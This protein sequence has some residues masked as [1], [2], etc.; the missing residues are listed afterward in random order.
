MLV[1]DG[2][3][4]AYTY[5]Y[6]VCVCVV[7]RRQGTPLRA[8]P[9][10]A[11][12]R[13]R[14]LHTHDTTPAIYYVHLFVIMYRA[15]TP[16]GKRS[17]CWVTRAVRAIMNTASRTWERL[18]WMC[19]TI[20]VIF[21]FLW[22]FSWITT[23]LRSML[24]CVYLFLCS[25]GMTSWNHSVNRARWPFAAD[26]RKDCHYLYFAK[27]LICMSCAIC[28]VLPSTLTGTLFIGIFI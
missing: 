18:C 22:R 16:G 7:L 17:I 14:S 9:H 27:D 26:C 24:R 6:C 13:A 3:A 28:L 15:R 12:R 4:F 23:N 21:V 20:T 2:S 1:V 8:A 25:M 10:R 19:T 11:A 5:W